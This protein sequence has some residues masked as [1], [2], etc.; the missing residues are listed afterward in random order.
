MGAFKAG[1]HKGSACKHLYAYSHIKLTSFSGI[2]DCENQ[3]NGVHFCTTNS[4]N[5]ENLFFYI[6]IKSFQWLILLA[7]FVNT[8]AQS[9][10]GENSTISTKKIK[11]NSSFFMKIILDPEGIK[12][13]KFQKRLVYDQIFTYQKSLISKSVVCSPRIEMDECIVHLKL[14]WMKRPCIFRHMI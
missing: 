12:R 5:G 4:W 2:D 1:K 13:N 9:E 3:R 10:N 11:L 14:I 8:R 7:V 6:L